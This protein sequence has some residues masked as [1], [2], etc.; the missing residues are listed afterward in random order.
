MAAQGDQPRRRVAISRRTLPYLLILPAF[1]VELLVHVLPILVGVLVSLLHLTRRQLR[2][3]VAAPYAGLD[4]YRTGL[5]IGG[6]SGADLLASAGRTAAY[7][8]LVVG[9]CWLLGILA[10]VMLASPFR[11]RAAFQAFFLVPFA[12][13]AYVSVLAWRFILDRD[14]GM[15]NHLL[16]DDLHLLGQ[17]PFWLVGS[18][19]F[20]STVLVSVWRLWPFAY[21]VLA[22]ALRTVPVEMY[23]AA[24]VDG[25]GAWQQFRHITLPATGRASAL[26]IL[27]MALWTV[28]DFST[29]FLLFDDTPPP[30]ATMLASLVYRTGFVDYDLGVASAMNVLI[31]VVL[32]LLAGLYARRLLS[33]RAVDA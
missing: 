14:D 24:S 20:W 21:L 15:L 9:T 3:W 4:N 28:T 18:N 32:L 10:A 19:A 26:A 1:V 7:T 5:D 6:P 2:D 25:A 17:R 16:V 8:V 27:V 33:G 13:P 30:A 12:L 22:A 29:P 23:R 31:A 11:G